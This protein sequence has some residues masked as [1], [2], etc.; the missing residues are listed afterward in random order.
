[1]SIL[2]DILDKTESQIDELSNMKLYEK[3]RC[4]AVHRTSYHIKRL[5]MVMDV[6]KLNSMCIGLCK[7]RYIPKYHAINFDDDACQD[8]CTLIINQ[9]TIG[10]VD[11]FMSVLTELVLDDVSINLIS[12]E[13]KK[14]PSQDDNVKI[15]FSFD[16]NNETDDRGR[17]IK[18]NVY[19]SEKMK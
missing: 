6:K 7:Q 15:R 17:S 3:Y 16:L 13:H 14:G 11:S 4:N 1:M 2:D 9:N 12:V 19:L 5:D 10:Y 8:L 18:F